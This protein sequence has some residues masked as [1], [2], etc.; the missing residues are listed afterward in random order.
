MMKTKVFAA[1]F[2]LP[3]CMFAQRS[4]LHS[5]DDLALIEYDTNANYA[6]IPLMLTSQTLFLPEVNDET[7]KRMF[8]G[9]PLYNYADDPRKYS[10][11]DYPVGKTKQLAGKYFTVM[12]YVHDAEGL[13]NVYLK[14]LVNGTR[15][16]VY[17][18]YPVPEERYKF[19]FAV[20]SFYEKMKDCYIN[21]QFVYRGGFY[22]LDV[23]DTKFNRK[24]KMKK[25]EVLRCLDFVIKDG[26]YQ[27]LM[28]NESGRKFYAPSDYAI[29]DKLTFENNMVSAE[30]IEKYR[31]TYPSFF[32]AILQ[33]RII[34][35]MTMDMVLMAW[36][37]PYKEV[38]TNF[39]GTNQHWY[40][41]GD[42]YVIFKD[43]RMDR[44]VNG[45]PELPE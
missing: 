11:I 37:K 18:K 9:T 1:L 44:I 41:P 14:L 20:M 27:M 32:D 25:G 38:K 28:K 45:L 39:S 30:A 26:K 31:H 2:L 10:L 16:T 35:D 15:D 8:H 3:L 43:N 34:K 5:N 7:L 23:K 40:Y 22:A 36:G 6:F 4:G 29:G 13:T 21:R 12:D 33:K 42:F 19:P 17:F 24:L